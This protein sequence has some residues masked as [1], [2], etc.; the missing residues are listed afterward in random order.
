MIFIGSIFNGMFNVVSTCAYGNTLDPVKIKD[1]W[2]EQEKLLAEKGYSKDE[3]EFA[4]KDWLLLDAKRIFIENSYD[5]II[6]SIGI[7]NN[8]RLIELASSILIKKL[9]MSLES[10]KNDTDLI[11]DSSDTMDNC[12][13]IVLKDEDYTIGRVLEYCLYNKYFKERKEINYVG[14]LKKHPHDNDSHIKISFKNIISKDD[15]IVILEDC[16]NSSILLLNS[17]KEYF[18]DK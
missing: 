12:Y 5:F 16:V 7:Y 14:F 11:K 1:A 15:I 8:F 18:S 17:I 3:I 13:I 9:Y 2:V 10:L 4:K 6:K